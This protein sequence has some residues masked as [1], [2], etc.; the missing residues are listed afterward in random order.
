MLVV[1]YLRLVL[2]MGLDMLEQ[3]VQETIR[4][5]KTLEGKLGYLTE[6]R[7]ELLMKHVEIPQGDV[8]RK[9][10]GLVP[11][12]PHDSLPARLR[13]ISTTVLPSK[14]NDFI[15]L[16]SK[17]S[18]PHIGFVVCDN[19]LVSVFEVTGEVIST[20]ALQ[21]ILLCAGSSTPEEPMIAVVS[22]FEITI[23]ALDGNSI[24]LLTSHT[25]FND[26]ATP[27]NL[28]NYSRLGKKFWLVGD[29]WGRITF[30]SSSGECLGQG[31]TGTSKVSVLDKFGS[32]IVYAGDHKLGIFNLATMEPYQECEPTVGRIIDVAQ[33][34]SATIIYAATDNHE[35]IVYD[36]KHSSPSSA[37]FCKAVA[38]M[39]NLHDIKKLAVL[40]NSLLAASDSVITSY[41]VSLLEQEVFFPP[42]HYQI[43]LNLDRIGIKSLRLPGAGNYLMVYGTGK[44]L[45]FDVGV[46]GNVQ[47]GGDWIDF[48]GV[49]VLAI[50]MTIGGVFLWR[51]VNGKRSSE[52]KKYAQDTETGHR[53]SQKK[54]K[55]NDKPQ[56]FR[57]NDDE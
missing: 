54:V 15:A 42:T 1:L 21:G 10:P 17:D 13:H 19:S 35:V 41:N 18:T 33:D 16:R 29:D 40:R 6:L 49:K 38:R 34:F 45:C 5:A 36:T 2:G 20:Y 37:P 46:V 52:A 53:G 39:P 3:E 14:S 51:Y 8:W 47:A 26:T 44:V 25:L 9:M 23:L 56:T 57:Y 7:E 31:S 28:I 48:G 27:T 55:F 30:Y 32:Q 11:Q 24:V 4:L 50:V 22:N 12:P 43:N